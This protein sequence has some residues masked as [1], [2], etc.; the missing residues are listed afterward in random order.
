MLA[1]SLPPPGVGSQH[2]ATG[3]NSSQDGRGA[4]GVCKPQVYPGNSHNSSP[5]EATTDGG[6]PLCL[7]TDPRDSISRKEK[8]KREPREEG[9]G[10]TGA[11]CWPPAHHS[12]LQRVPQGL[13][14]S[15]SRGLPHQGGLPQP[16]LDVPSSH[17]RGILGGVDPNSQQGEA[18]HLEQGREGVMPT[19]CASQQSTGPSPSHP[20]PHQARVRSYGGVYTPK[21]CTWLVLNDT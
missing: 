16:R 4:S 9:A 7:C 5:T 10:S 20:I 17:R 12:Y 15:D 14:R 6:P 11:G 13:Q 18:S 21:S 19:S 8:A 2:H 3:S 1:R